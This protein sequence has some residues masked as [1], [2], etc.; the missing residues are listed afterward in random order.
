MMLAGLGWLTF[1][2]PPLATALLPFNLMSGGLGE[3]ALTIWLL[4]VGLNEPRWNDQA[5]VE[6]EA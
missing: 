5:K 3:G 6:G 2:Y 4:W 1:I